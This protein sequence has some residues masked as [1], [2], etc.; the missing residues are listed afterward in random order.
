MRASRRLR[1]IVVLAALALAAPAWADFESDYVAG[2]AAL[3][4]ADYAKAESYLKKA[5]DA[6]S[7]PVRSVTI[8]GNRQPYLPYHFLGMA[9]FRRGDCAL[10]RSQWDN[11]MNR[12]MLGRLYTLKREEDGLI[13]KCQAAKP[14]V[15]VA[16]ATATTAGA[17]HASAAAFVAPAALIGA[18]N[19]YV[20][21]QYTKVSRIDPQ[22]FAD[23]RAQFPALVLR[24][25]ARFALSRLGGGSS[26]LNG[27]R[28]DARAAQ[29]LDQSTLDARVFSP[30]FRAF[31]ASAK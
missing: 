18:F 1:G 10:A 23:K 21:G 27:A 12:R 16:P 26:M 11:P 9:A 31:Y 30:A 14:V 28:S 22:A 20:A 6:Q 4:H 2:L 15:K 25:A 19:D 3:D 5:L 29:A 8:N 24:A 7:N 17:T 13:D